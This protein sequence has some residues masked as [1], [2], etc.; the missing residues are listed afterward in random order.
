MRLIE[1]I[2]EKLALPYV[3]ANTAVMNRGFIETNKFTKNR[4]EDRVRALAYDKPWP[5]NATPNDAF[6]LA[7]HE[8]LIIIREEL[9]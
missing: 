1:M 4:V 2:R 7:I 5:E 8:A 6:N 3:M 9:K